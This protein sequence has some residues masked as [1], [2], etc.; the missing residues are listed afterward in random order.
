MNSIRYAFVL[1]VCMVSF[2][3]PSEVI[4]G[5]LSA[6]T[7][8]DMFILLEG[9]LLLVLVLFLANKFAEWRKPNPESE[10]E[11]DINSEKQ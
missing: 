11:Q 10:D 3:L 8:S 4:A 2:L 1:L 7:D 6:T 9:S 5:G